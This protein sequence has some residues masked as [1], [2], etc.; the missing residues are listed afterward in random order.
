[1]IFTDEEYRS[2]SSRTTSGFIQKGSK[3]SSDVA[4]VPGGMENVHVCVPTAKFLQL[5]SLQDDP[6]LRKSPKS[7]SV[8]TASNCTFNNF[9]INVSTEVQ[10]K[11]QLKRQTLLQQANE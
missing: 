2:L 11:Q 3:R 5:E 10:E 7:S 8:L 9:A 6:A 4:A 1:M